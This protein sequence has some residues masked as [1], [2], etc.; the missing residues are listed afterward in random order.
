MQILVNRIFKT[1]SKACNHE[2]R[3]CT[4]ENSALATTKPQL[5]LAG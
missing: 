1:F 4:V 5:T 3:L 2:N